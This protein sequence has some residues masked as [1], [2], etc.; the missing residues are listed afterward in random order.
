MSIR[1]TPAPQTR[2]GAPSREGSRLSHVLTVGQRSGA[3]TCMPYTPASSDEDAAPEVVSFQASELPSLELPNAA[4]KA[5]KQRK[6]AYHLKPWQ[7]RLYYAVEVARILYT[8]GAPTNEHRAQSSRLSATHKPTAQD[9]AA[10]RQLSSPDNSRW[11]F[12]LA[13]GWHA[14]AFLNE[15]EDDLRLDGV[16][17]H[18][19]GYHAKVQWWQENIGPRPL[20]VLLQS[21]A[22]AWSLSTNPNALLNRLLEKHTRVHIQ[23]LLPQQ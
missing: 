11:N 3:A 19:Y 16:D 5:I 15:D 17:V 13:Y 2:A 23:G 8:L 12:W 20:P 22:G 7:T 14:V 9:Q 18:H 1:P 10:L 6:M 4:V 21:E